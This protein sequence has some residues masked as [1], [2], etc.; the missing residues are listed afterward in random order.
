MVVRNLWEHYAF[1]MDREFLRWGLSHSQ[2]VGRNFISTNL[3][4]EPK[5]KWLVTGPSNSPE[6][7]FRLPD[8]R[9]A[10]VCL[11]PTIDMQTAPRVVRQHRRA[12]PKFSAWMRISAPG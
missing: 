11:G 2:G 1:T 7:A 12:P 9:I 4:E 6:N 10:H 8:G 5:H 3:I